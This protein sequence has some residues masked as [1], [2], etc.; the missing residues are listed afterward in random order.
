LSGPDCYSSQLRCLNKVSCNPLFNYRH[1]YMNTISLTKRYT[2]L[3]T[4][5][6][7][8]YASEMSD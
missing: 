5:I 1:S 7:K 4:A 6:F 2:A 8:V 3:I